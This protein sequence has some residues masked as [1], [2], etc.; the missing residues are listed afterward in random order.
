MVNFIIAERFVDLLTAPF[1]YTDML[2]TLT[3]LFLTAVFME[4]YFARYKFEDMGWNSA[5]GNVL[6]LIFVAIDLF[7]YLHVH[8]E[9]TYL[10]PRNILVISLTIIG[11]ALSVSNF[12]HAWSKKLAYG[13]SGHLPINFL[14]FMAV[15]LVYS[16]LPIDFI[17]FISS[18][19]ILILLAAF[20]LLIKY[21]VP[22]AIELDEDEYLEREN[23]PRP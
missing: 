17:T 6:V 14:A 2:W 10:T 18:I 11:I 4:L 9:L 19:G 20:I 12:L 21:I 15:L 23:A 8:N 16:G 3:P 7:R 22:K 1:T 5:Y 13:I